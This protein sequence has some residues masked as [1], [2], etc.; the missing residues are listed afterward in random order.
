M[1]REELADVLAQ[2]VVD[3]VGKFVDFGAVWEKFGKVKRVSL[4]ISLGMFSLM[5]SSLR[6]FHHR[7]ACNGGTRNL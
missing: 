1:S 6:S 3:E 4:G 7:K 2:V 5:T